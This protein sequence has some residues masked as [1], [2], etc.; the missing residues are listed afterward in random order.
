MKQFLLPAL[1][2][3]SSA[4]LC[5]PIQTPKNNAA[6]SNAL[7][8]V[9]QGY[10]KNFEGSKGDILSETNDAIS[11]QSKVTLPQSL[12]CVIVRY[13]H[14]E[15]YSWEALMFESDDY[16]EVVM[17]YDQLFRQM[18]NCKLT[19]NGYDK[20]LL[21]GNYDKPDE[22]RKFAASHFVLDTNV[23]GRRNFSIELTMQ[24]QFPEWSVKILMYEKIPDEEMRQG[25][26]RLD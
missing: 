26:K 23:S 14:P 11:Y 6:F 5:Q 24:Y 13:N 18:N 1:L 21:T 16:D 20:V 3:V 10:F 25:M 8:E 22:G 7:N 2:L 9:A 17:K 4:V 19:L 15:A 12:S